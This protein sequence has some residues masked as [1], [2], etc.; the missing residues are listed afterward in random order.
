MRDSSDCKTDT[1]KV[2]ATGRIYRHATVRNFRQDARIRVVI[3][4][5]AQSA[6]SGRFGAFVNQPSAAHRMTA[7]E[8]NRV[9]TIQGTV[10]YFCLE[11]N[12]NRIQDRLYKMNAAET[13]CLYFTVASE[14]IG[15]GLEEQIVSFA[16]AHSDLKL[17]VI[18]VMQLI[19]SETESSYGSDYAGI[20]MDTMPMKRG[21]VANYDDAQC[22][23]S[24]DLH[25]GYAL[26][27]ASDKLDSIMAF[28]FQHAYQ[29]FTVI[30]IC[31]LGAVTC[32][33]QIPAQWCFPTSNM[34]IWLHYQELLRESVAP[35]SGSFFYFIV[36][37]LALL[38]A[39]KLSYHNC[40]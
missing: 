14:R 33:L 29:I 26:M 39:T 32:A 22:T 21:L 5:T 38:T 12:Y 25:P 4:R 3:P 8:E 24:Y 28:G 18:D 16:K 35:I 19:R 13:E 15:S 11:D 30:A 2:T 20:R 6:H 27:I 31:A 10:L 34:M 7:D 23:H 36:C 17:V 9:K 40:E 1:D 37:D